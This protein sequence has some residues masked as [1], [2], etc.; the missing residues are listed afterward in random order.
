MQQ[1]TEAP[2]YI[3]T[4]FIKLVSTIMSKWKFPLSPSALIHVKQ[5]MKVHG[6]LNLISTPSFYLSC[7]IIDIRK[8]EKGFELDIGCYGYQLPKKTLIWEGV[9]TVLSRNKETQKRNIGAHARKQK[10]LSQAEDF[11]WSK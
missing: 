3:E 11:E 5:T 1:P 10:E 8:V 2:C 7:N 6:D 9:M 4:P